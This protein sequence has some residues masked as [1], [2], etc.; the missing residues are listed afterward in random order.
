[1]ERQLD[2]VVEPLGAPLPEPR[3][4]LGGEPACRLGVADERGGLLFGGRLGFELDPV[5]P[6][7]VVEL[8]PRTAGVDE[9]SG[10]QRVLGRR[11]AEAEGFRVVCGD[12][13]R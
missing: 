5:L 11:A 4:E 12:L 10:E 7:E 8:V 13:L 6:R 2:L 1:R 3:A 9:V